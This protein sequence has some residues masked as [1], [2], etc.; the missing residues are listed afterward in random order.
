[1]KKHLLMLLVAVMAT[2]MS[3]QAKVVLIDEGFENGIQDS[4][5]TQEFV[6]G[7][8]PWAVE[9]VEDSLAWPATTK[10]G[11]K[12]AYL[13][14]TTGETQ[15]YK[16][17]LVSKVMDLSPRKV[18]QPEL[19]FWYANPKWG[20]D[21]DTLR[22]LYRSNPNGKWKQ[23][24]EFSTAM[25]NW[26]KVNIEL[27]EV[28]STY[29]IA[30][31][32][33]D[34]LGRGIVL[35]SITLRS[36]PECTVPHDITVSN[37]GAGKV[38]IA[39]SASWDATYFELVVAK[40]TIDPEMASELSDDLL[41]FYGRVSGLEQSYDLTLEAGQYYYVYIRSICEGEISAWSSEDSKDGPYRFRVRVTKQIPYYCD[42]SMPTAT[43]EPQR[44]AE[45]T[46]GGNTGNMNPYI[47]TKSTSNYSK[48][49][50]ACVIFSGANDAATSVPAGSYVFMATPAITDSLASNFNV[51]QCQVSFWSTVY[52]YTG[53]QYA[54]SIIVGV[55]DDPDDVTTF[56]PVDTVSVWGTKTFQENIV[57]LSS[58]QG[59]GS[60][61]AFMSDFD[62]PNNFYID[63]VT[64][65]YRKSVNKVTKI[66]VNPRD[67]YADIAWEGN[68][69]SYKIVIAS[70]DVDP[71][72]IKARNLVD[73]AT[74][75]TNHYT[76]TKLK[77]AQGWNRPYYVY[78]QAAG[79]EW[80]YRY[81]FIT[82]GASQV[83]PY[84]FNFGT[85]DT[86]TISAHGSSYAYLK[87]LGIYSNDSYYPYT[88]TNHYYKGPK[89]LFLEKKAGTDAW[90]VLP[91][92]E[93]LDST[94]VKFYLS[95]GGD[96]TF[97]Y[98]QSHATIGVIANP[99]DISTF[100]PVA[101]FTLTTT[102][103][104]M[105]YA[106]FQNYQGPD[107]LIAI[108][109]SDVKGLGQSTINY[110]D[111]VKVEKLSECIPPSNVD[112]S[113]ESDSITLTW[114]ASQADM[115]E[116]IV[117][118]ASLSA[119]QKENSLADLAGLQKVVI[120]D[121]LRWDDPDT[122][123]EFGIGGLTPQTEYYLYFRTVC[124]GDAA[125][126]TEMQFHTP[127]PSYDFP[128]KEDFESYASSSKTA[129]CW[130]LMDYLG[131]GYPM[132]YTTNG[133]KTLEL[134]STSGHRCIAMM[135]S[136][137]G[138]LSDM[139]LCFETRSYS[140]SSSTATVLYVGTMADINNLSSFVPFD[141]IRNPGGSDFMK[142]RL[143]LDD[144]YLA[145]DNIAFYSG[146]TS[147][148]VLIDNVELKSAN[149]IEAYNFRQTDAQETSVD[150]AWDGKSDN[151]QWEIRVLNKNISL[152]KLAQ[153]NYDLVGQTVVGDTVI[154]GRTFHVGNL[155]PINT[156]YV[157]IRTLCGD[158]LWTVHSVQTACAKLDPTRP[159][160]ET[161]ESYP[162]GTSYSDEYQAQC[163]S[164]TNST[165][166]KGSTMPYIY[167]SSNSPSGTN[168]YRFYPLSSSGTACCVA[169]P[170]IACDSLTEL[171]VT[172]SY[173]ATSSYTF[174][175]GVMLD[176][177]D[178]STFVTL[179]S[180]KCVSG[181]ATTVSMDLSEYE[182]VIPNNARYFAWRTAWGDGAPI[183]Y[184]DD[185]S[186]TKLNCPLSKPSYSDLTAQTVRI[187]GGLRTDDDWLLLVTN[188]PVSTDSLWSSTYRVP[189]SLIVYYDTIDVRS[190]TVSGLSDRT[191]YYV[192]T[193]TLCDSIASQ[194]SELTFMTPCIALTPEAMGT[195][196]FA[197]RDGFETGSSG[198]LPCWTV[199]SKTQGASSSY[200]PY[201]ANSSSD[202]HNGNN[203]LRMYD[204]VYGTT[205]NYVGAYA[206]MPELNV[207]TLN[208]YQV[209][210]WGRGYN[211]S[212]YNSQVIVGVVTDPSD[213][214]TF[215]A[216]DTVTL[217]KTT[218]EPFSVGFEDYE[219]D[220]LGEL[221]RYVMFLSEFG[222][223]NYAYISEV[224]V[225]LIPQ[226]R[227]VSA[228]TVDSVGENAA[229][230]SFNGYQDS[231]RLLVADK[232]LT[233]KEKKNYTY[234]I[235]TIVDHSDRI[236]L[237]DLT[238]I[239][240]Y[241][242]YAQGICADGDSTAVSMTYASVRTSC[243]TSTGLPIP[244]YDDF[245]SYE[246]NEQ[247]PGC[248]MFRSSSS[249]L[250]S[251]FAVKDVSS[252]GTQAVDFYSTGSNGSYAVLP[253]VEG[254]LADL[255]LS[256]DA[257]P[258]SGASASDQV[259]YVGTMTDPED[260]TT[261][262]ALET[263][264][265]TPSADFLTYEMILGNYEL[266]SN[267]LTITSGMTGIT[268][269]GTNDVY[270]DNVGL[271][272]VSSCHAPRL[273]A[274]NNSS[275]SIE[276]ELVPARPENN[277]W[278]YV[279]IIDSVY[280]KIRN[281]ENYLKTAAYVTTDSTHIVL[282]NL[283][284]A[285]TYY[286]YARTV[287][288]GEDGNSDWSREPLK[289]HT[290]FYYQ[291]SY[292]FGF[293]KSERW[294][295]SINSA[296]DSYYLHPALEAGRDSL[297]TAST[298]Y[299]YYPYSIENTT[300]NLYSHTDNG[301]LVMTSSGNYHGAYVIFPA[302]D[303]PRRR[304]FE[305]KVRPGYVSATSKL[306]DASTRDGIIEIGTV[307]KNKAFD[308]YQALVTVRL[309]KLNTAYRASTD[310]NELFQYY[311]IDLDSATIADKQ[312][313]LHS[314]K[315]PSG[316]STL[317]IDDVT[318]GATKGFSLVA[319]DNI[320]ADG[321]SATISWANIGG[322]W[323]LY[324]LNEAGDTVQSYPQIKKAT[325][326]VVTGLQPRTNYTA[327]LEALNAPANTSYNTQAIMH[328]STTCAMEEPTSNG[329]FYWDFDDQY[330]W[331]ANDVLEGA[332][333]D[334]TYLQ[335]SCF[336][337]GITYETPRNGYQWLIQ[338]KGYDYY[339]TLMSY[340]D[341]RHQ[342]VGRNDSHSL[343]VYTT[344]SYYNS[345]IVLPELH[346][347]FDTMMLEFYGR[348]FVN[349]DE[350]T[351]SVSDRGKIIGSAYL[352][353]GYSQSIVVATLS[354]LNDAS[355]LQ[356]IDTLTYKQTNL[357]S[358]DNVN[359]DPA[360]LRY[361]ELMQLPLKNAQGKYIVLF[362]P[363]P[364]LFFID[365]MKV[366]PMGNTLFAPTHT[367]T[368]NITGTS[369][370]L[371][372]SVWHEDKAS[373]V[374]V[375]NAA[376]DQEI[377]RDTVTTTNYILT[378]LNAATSYQWYV[379]QTDTVHDSPACVLVPFATECVDIKAPYSCGFEFAD[380]WSL[381]A[382]Q[383]TYTQ[384]LCW[385][386]SDALQNEWVSSSYDPYN[387]KNT[388]S[389]RYS[390]TDSFAVGMRA[391]SGYSYTYQPYIALPAMDV[392][393]YD[394]LQLVFW[395]RP[396]YTWAGSGSVVTSYTG[397]T[398]AKSVIVGTMTDPNNAA[399]FVAI[400]TLTY[401][402]AI[403][404]ADV[405]TAANSYLYQQKKLDLAGATGPYI[406]FMTT[407]R[408]KGGTTDK[409]NDYIWLD[410]ISIIRA[411]ECKDPTNLNNDRIG[412]T[413][414]VLS[415]V[416]GDSVFVLQVSTDPTFEDE[417]AF[418]FNDTVDSNPYT[419]T[420]LGKLT[421]Y[422]W[423]VQ[424][425]CGGGKGESN[426]SAM[427]TFTTARS[428]YFLEEFT[429]AVNNEWIF[430]MSKAENIMDQSASVTV[431]SNARSFNRTTST[432]GQESPHYV[433]PGYKDDYHWMITPSFYL[434]END[435][436][437]FSMDLA[438]TACNT[439]RTPTAN[440]V[441]ESDMK[442][443]YYFMV[444]VS[445]DGGQ[446]WKSEN[447][448]AKWQNTN[449]EGQQLRDIPVDGMTVRYSLA[450]YAGKNIR[451]GLYREAKTSVTTGIA[452]HVDNVRLAYFDKIIDY[453]T[454]CQY[455]DIQV[456]NIFLS[457]DDTR[458]GLHTYPQ[459]RYVSDSLAR[460]GVNDTVYSLEIEVFEVT[461]T[462][463][464]DTI[465]EGETFTDFNF[466][467]KSVSGKYRRKL[468]SS[469]DC[470]SVIT[471]YLNVIPRVYAE[472]EIAVL[473]GNDTYMWNGKPYNRAG[474][475]RDTLVS[476][477][478][479]DSIMTLVVSKGTI[480]DTIRVANRV[481]LSEL[482]FT[483]ENAEHP[484]IAGQSSI[485]YAAGTPKGEYIDTVM[486]EGTEC[487]RVLVHYLTIYDK[488]DAIDNVNADGKGARKVI[489]RDN[490]YIILN[491]E[492]Y[493][494]S[495]LKVA[496]PR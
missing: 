353:S 451:I 83:L 112:L 437:H 174:L 216:V 80:S 358:Y 149:C 132:I 102:G 317:Y 383:T 88:V 158:S 221:G 60:Y 8:T 58:Y 434:P 421:T 255:M 189:E 330:A 248:W 139:L 481:E 471:L 22:V 100:T 93:D 251:W 491:D 211:S 409:A 351:T 333:S 135:P 57:D 219:G 61:I 36:A 357:T 302:V 44:D 111:E 324:I 326:Q 378:D 397:S 113:V 371:A 179:D 260:P 134:W 399:T 436:V 226:C 169:S 484:Y 67:T 354:D 82:L 213:L 425:I 109:W 142:V 128:Y 482:P 454:G 411:Q 272:M 424:A 492:W 400:D 196:T 69:S 187:S 373:V 173:Y 30:F 145:Y 242:V 332:S 19:S 470:D 440:A 89:S 448:L 389:Y 218:W 468:L 168:S 341:T 355:T 270:I 449:P 7:E 107:G 156:Y 365:D 116:V 15:G 343:R 38:T 345:Y 131:T 346:C 87:G 359:D 223:T 24:R 51:N 407:F 18:Y 487:A 322:P 192:Y 380:G 73:S 205:S 40:D 490:L 110:I 473:C 392:N 161:F 99:M 422:V 207:D 237:S 157:Y 35:D 230:V 244:F 338:Q 288:G 12:R 315:Q 318:L 141:T 42:F 414:A 363:A 43:S 276:A 10:Q 91:P 176:P 167:N 229:I 234:L 294:T 401:E 342:E 325:S 217:N 271:T 194:W 17:R 319:I 304:S 344:S 247:E 126:W 289:V 416:G 220:Y 9:S 423:R 281:I 347:D 94:Q 455:E 6:E 159:N 197:E 479:C 238:P 52:S 268:E 480:E 336:H 384:A 123:P 331:E 406:A 75:T 262:V 415:W 3:L 144:Y 256:F 98:L 379:Y 428:P 340:S 224:K 215:V 275:N 37:K 310:N 108:V 53:R 459:P 329:E 493:N 71:A 461:E 278:H 432:N 232:V 101:D 201:V 185:I 59:T 4:V 300:S 14:N 11:S 350:S 68:A 435:S 70:S 488:D 147:N 117:A 258:Y 97:G 143:V 396:A 92:V 398:Y 360:G 63:D 429:K 127:C 306:P 155:E 32:G 478:G 125:W 390:R 495:G 250:S 54:H 95:G 320:I 413:D 175:T 56:V 13:R 166:T 439:S 388:D 402:G 231:Y 391:Y 243:P 146:T 447:I 236:L 34:N 286:I 209:T 472:D 410:D 494:A 296:S 316:A 321:T 462:V 114:D 394:T 202:M 199:G 65:D 265:I 496:D 403:S 453:A 233:D 118:K 337:V 16:T 151:D 235:D 284:A 452:I 335:P 367:S 404:T 386:Y 130:Q 72:T 370:E 84:T 307:D 405:A 188:A 445:D 104:T 290:Q 285:T 486:V 257:R 266:T 41:A 312:L 33:S 463:Y 460:L 46:W 376:G 395:M 443:D 368:G 489:I 253:A 45:W 369:A 327:R 254:N 210:F 298:T 96:G 334:E 474:L 163:W 366:K 348:C 385:T 239:T 20:A 48:D 1:M 27:P 438:L 74:V 122:A 291:N 314:P 183:I 119:A 148:D 76:C 323:G 426:F 442:D 208:K 477:L 85:E 172:Y 433:A 458:P 349:Y 476:S 259:I 31:E 182:G 374:V 418:V 106:N 66:S 162:S 225:E 193:A 264:D 444:I 352:G 299:S 137:E 204:Y 303:E 164:V 393:A 295:R 177:Y 129:G 469:H 311:T 21:R 86:Y 485:Y 191:N 78:I 105:C 274:L 140:S 269:D 283:D 301:A 382:G 200:I 133:N 263:F 47:M 186:I 372:W 280:T 287:C 171:V 308:T 466:Q 170:E 222:V 121:T 77:A 160:K 212:S 431:G 39:W 483:Y 249:S 214:N 456:G 28:G 241:Y 152:T 430:S 465:C 293:E 309:E 305:F 23:L 180:F 136:V 387:Y 165:N 81:P 203:Y 2:V 115:W 364:G 417:E 467:G 475:Y 292:F 277:L 252:N 178:L 138:D 55:M 279:V 49:K 377:L 446:T 297:G 328:F 313:V 227:P 273:K 464:H 50:T 419:V 64:V 29:Q 79:Q 420:G 124:N 181:R 153:N 427:N 240:T 5:W 381:I 25:A 362:Q 206:I 26:Q 356:I 457:G 408:E 267:Y 441:A 120:A 190:K 246:L 261:F 245:E 195:I 103:Y 62:L 154:T 90:M 375:L 184:L 282:D 361:W 412:A 198:F 339:S 228:F 450:Q 150:F